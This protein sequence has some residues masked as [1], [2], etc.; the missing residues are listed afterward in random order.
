M[1][2]YNGNTRYMCMIVRLFEEKD[3]LQSFNTLIE[4]QA[5]MSVCNEH[6]H[7]L[8]RMASGDESEVRIIDAKNTILKHFE[9][10]KQQ[11]N[12]Q[13]QEDIND[14][15]SIKTPKLREALLN[16]Y[17]ARKCKVFIHTIS[18][19]MEGNF[20]TSVNNMSTLGIYP[21]RKFD[22]HMRK[23]EQTVDNY[24]GVIPDAFS[25]IRYIT[26]IIHFFGEAGD[27]ES[28]GM[29]TNIPELVT[30]HRN[31]QPQKNGIIEF[32]EYCLKQEEE[33]NIKVSANMDT[34]LTTVEGLKNLDGYI[35]D[36]DVPENNE[37]ILPVSDNMSWWNLNTSSC[38]KEANAA[39][40][41]GSA[42]YDNTLFSLR[43]RDEVFVKEI[44]KVVVVYRP[45]ITASINMNSK[46]MY[47]CR[48]NGNQK[49]SKKYHD[50]IVKMLVKLEIENIASNG[51][52]P[53]ETF[54]LSDLS[55]DLSKYLYSK[56]VA[57]V[58]EDVDTIKIDGY[59]FTLEDHSSK[60]YKNILD[61]FHPDK[62]DID[63]DYYSKILAG[64]YMFDGHSLDLS[65]IK[66]YYRDIYFSYNGN[67]LHK[68]IIKS[69]ISDES[70]LS[71]ALNAAIEENIIED[72]PTIEEF[73][74]WITD[75]ADEDDIENII[76]NSND[77]LGYYDNVSR[78]TE[79][80]DRNANEKAFHDL[81][82]DFLGQEFY[83]KYEDEYDYN[84][85]FSISAHIARENGL[86][87]K[88][89]LMF[90][91]G[92]RDSLIEK[93]WGFGCMRYNNSF[94][95]HLEINMSEVETIDFE[96][97][98]RYGASAEDKDHKSAW[99]EY[100]IYEVDWADG[101]EPWKLFKDNENS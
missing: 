88:Y 49:P 26:R 41:C 55:E 37:E 86:N 52:K 30:A 24:V 96:R 60:E 56:L 75:N 17:K 8:T 66:S 20:I 33:F 81:F 61:I 82:N 50:A 38:R 70:E 3:H 79:E 54:L 92:S 13:Y 32:L 62:R 19:Y 28:S 22:R 34:T 101:L 85:N 42:G 31:W 91:A 5:L 58:P 25:I 39:N 40:H 18:S 44:N 83:L 65:T 84:N 78:S 67:K 100:G 7:S 59:G 72:G 21:S 11:V 15:M 35:L 94:F 1:T 53:E 68:L 87:G 29:T 6:Q 27:S 14:T 23:M 57:S 2:K 71:K 48:A 64:E 95:N 4:I 9:D 46:A 74:S 93:L 43:R 47:E 77:V 69:I 45:L 63:F 36:E 16:L 51:Y 90:V 97:K 99:E 10:F 80:A 98:Y 12:K 73:K 76:L 89:A